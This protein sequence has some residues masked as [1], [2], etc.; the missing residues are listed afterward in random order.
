M[1][2]KL[3]NFTSFMVLFPA[4]SNDM[5]PA[6]YQNFKLRDKGLCGICFFSNIESQ[7]RFDVVTFGV[8]FLSGL[9]TVKSYRFF[10]GVDTLGTLS[11]VCEAFVTYLGRV[12]S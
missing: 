5:L 8:S 4:A 6:R 11:H 9:T 3:G 10:L 7:D 2:L 1:T 12:K